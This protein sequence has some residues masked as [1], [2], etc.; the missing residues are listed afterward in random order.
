LGGLGNVLG[1]RDNNFDGIIDLIIILI[2]LEFLCGLLSDERH[3]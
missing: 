3:C 1:R 2:A